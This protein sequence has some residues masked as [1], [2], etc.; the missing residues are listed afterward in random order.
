MWGI[1]RCVCC[2]MCAVL[3]RQLVLLCNWQSADSQA[4]VC[5]CATWLLCW[6]R[7]LGKP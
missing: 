6:L 2:V 3:R 1:K 5:A 7:V 4:W